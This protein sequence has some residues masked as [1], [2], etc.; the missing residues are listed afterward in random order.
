MRPRGRIDLKKIAQE[1]EN[2]MDN[3]SELKY[4]EV[5]LF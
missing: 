3:Y 4:R 2:Q 5:Y 1:N